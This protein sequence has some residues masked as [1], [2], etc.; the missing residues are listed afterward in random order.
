MD[1][2]KQVLASLTVQLDR[3]GLAST[4]HEA[5]RYRRASAVQDGLVNGHASLLILVGDDEVKVLNVVL[6]SS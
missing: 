4:V 1:R 2:F 3:C 6:L 5:E